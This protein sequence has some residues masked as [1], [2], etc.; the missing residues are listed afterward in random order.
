MPA[1]TTGC[2]RARRR[3]QI[4]FMSTLR[5]AQRG[6]GGTRWLISLPAEPA[7]SV[8]FRSTICRGR[9]LSSHELDRGRRTL[10]RRLPRR[11]VRGSRGSRSSVLPHHARG[12]RHRPQRVQAAMANLPARI[13][14]RRLEDRLHRQDRRAVLLLQADPEDAEH[15]AAL[16]ADVRH[17]GRT[18]QHRARRRP[19]TRWS[20]GCSRSTAA[21]TT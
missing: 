18:H 21:A 19:A 13:R 3:K 14:R 12:G 10:R 9:M 7:S 8:A 11:H 17:R 20:Q 6:Q 4:R 2:A 1:N 5:R 16:G 15:A